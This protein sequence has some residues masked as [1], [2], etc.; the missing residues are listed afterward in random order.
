M[1]Q[2]E[3]Q[4]DTK[5]INN[6]NN[7]KRLIEVIKQQGSQNKTLIKEGDINNVKKNKKLRR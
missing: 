4:N 7:L 1:I 2:L 6:I 5:K 3:N